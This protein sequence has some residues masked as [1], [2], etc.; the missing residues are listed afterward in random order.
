LCSFFS[1]CSLPGKGALVKDVFNLKRQDDARKSRHRNQQHWSGT[2][3]TIILSSITKVLKEIRRSILY[4][5]GLAAVERKLTKRRHYEGNI[6]LKQRQGDEPIDV[7]AIRFE[8][9]GPAGPETE[10]VLS[11]DDGQRGEGQ[12]RTRQLTCV[13]SSNL[14]VGL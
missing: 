6:D 3:V 2:Y 10:D 5:P 14:T 8:T 12:G 13:I 1:N 4:G 11:E 9:T 7:N